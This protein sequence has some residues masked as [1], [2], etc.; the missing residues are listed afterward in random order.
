MKINVTSG[1]A[2]ASAAL[3]LAVS[4]TSLMMPTKASAEG[5]KVHCMGV[6]SCKGHSDC[7]TASNSCKGQNA[8]KGQ[9]FLDVTKAECDSLGGTVQE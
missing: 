3:A 7:K 1:A 5:D 9:G 4:G 8:C 2:I 6:N